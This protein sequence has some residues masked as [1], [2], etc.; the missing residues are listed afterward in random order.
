MLGSGRV[1]SVA[2]DKIRCERHDPMGYWGYIGGIDFGYDHPTAFVSCAWDRDTDTFYV[3]DSYRKRAN[4]GEQHEL[5]IA[6]HAKAIRELAGDVRVAWPHDGH[7]HDSG[8][9]AGLAQQYR[10]C[11]VKMLPTHF[12]NPPVSK[13]GDGGNAVEPGLQAMLTAME[14]GRF[15]V[16]DT[17]GNQAW[18]QEYRLYHRKDGIVVKH[19]D[20][21]MSATRYAYQSRRFAAAKVRPRM[22]AT[23][24]TETNP[25]ENV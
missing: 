8:S 25:L 17:P 22:P 12:T 24:I 23:A 5:L 4:D 18:F 21:L 13:E 1:F 9:G 2:E 15:K 3:L 19:N 16:M 7:R 11:G 6:D 10:Q 20:D 14:C